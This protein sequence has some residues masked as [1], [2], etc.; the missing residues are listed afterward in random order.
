MRAPSTVYW[1]V[2]FVEPCLPTLGRAVPDGPLWIHEIKHDGYRFICRRFGDRIRVISRHGIEW[3]DRVPSIVDAIR[4]LHLKSA[5]IDGEGVI[6]DERGVTDFDALRF[7]LARRSAPEA[8]L[9][10]F[11]VFL[12]REPWEV[13]RKALASLLRK[14]GDG[15]RLSEHLEGGQGQ[16]IFRHACSMGLEGIVSKRRDAPYCS[17]RCADWIKVKNPN[18]PAATRIFE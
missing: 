15:I 11:D 8:L 16:A 9:Y 18:A 10:A 3:T 17:G 4:S 5:T 12:C 14:A 6:C 2:G 7:A 13:R 1:P